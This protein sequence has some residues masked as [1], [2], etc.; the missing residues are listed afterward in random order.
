M[1]HIEMGRDIKQ[2][3]QKSAE[4]DTRIYSADSLFQP[5]SRFF[6]ITFKSGLTE[7]AITPYSEHFLSFRLQNDKFSASKLVVITWIPF[8]SRTYL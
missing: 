4:N 7:R 6:D 5:S 1:N 3:T 2:R 8:Y